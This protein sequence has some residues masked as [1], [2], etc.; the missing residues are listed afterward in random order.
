MEHLPVNL[1]DTEL[2]DNTVRG[3]DGVQTLRD[4]GD[5]Q[6]ITKDQGT[7]GGRAIAC[8]TFSVEVDGKLVRAQTVTTVRLLATAL[9]ALRGRYDV[10]GK[11]KQ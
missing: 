1:N 8:L 6:I 3:L 11:A 7:E 4:A 2:F 9:S 5:L 10:D